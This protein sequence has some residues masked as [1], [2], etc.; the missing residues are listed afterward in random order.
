MKI[1]I[2]DLRKNI[3]KTLLDN[4][5]NDEDARRTIDYILWAEMSD[6]KTQGLVK[7]TGNWPLQDIKPLYVCRKLNE[8]LIYRS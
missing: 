2:Q 3:A 6:N 8:T 7:M 5:F 4:G 1:A